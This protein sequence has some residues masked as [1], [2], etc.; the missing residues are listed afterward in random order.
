MS[1]R[2]AEIRIGRASLF[3]LVVICLAAWVG[4]ASAAP[5]YLARRLDTEGRDI[6]AAFAPVVAEVRRSVVEVRL[7]NERVAFGTIVHADGLILTKA[8]EIVD[9]EGRLLN[10]KLPDGASRP[11]KRV[12]VDSPRDLALLKVDA[13][14]LVPISFD[15]DAPLTLGQWAVVP[16]PDEDPVAI[17]VLSAAARRVNGVRLGVALGD[18]DEGAMIGGVMDG[19][20][21]AE[22]GLKPGDVFVTIDD[23]PV[24][25]AVEVIEL[26]QSY[27]AGDVIQVVVRRGE[28]EL[29]FEVDLRLREID[30]RSRNDRMN[31]MG[32]EISRRRDGFDSVLQHD[33]T[34]DPDQCGGP[35]VDLNGRCIGV[36]IA[37]AGRIE[38]Y[39]LP[40]SEVR[41]A[42]KALGVVGEEGMVNHEPEA[43]ETHN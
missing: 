21:A 25:E 4:A 27:T 35:L 37:R 30:E 20:G 23:H 42:L 40:V 29:R 16:G 41:K 34:L 38:A 12:G 5:D 17:G 18:T 43:A 24:T 33:A 3:T 15:G 1:C 28:Q 39:T 6:L 7:N 9:D 10:V 13:A 32:N 11:A 36:N 26:L 19:M 8:S 22:A 31:T 2:S 14:G